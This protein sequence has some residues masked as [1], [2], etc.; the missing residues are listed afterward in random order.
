[1]SAG[2]PLE[3]LCQGLKASDRSA[4]EHL[5]RLFRQDLL[6][7]VQSIVR[8]GTVA[9]DLVQ[10]VFVSLWGLRETLDPSQPLKPYLYRMARNRA[11]RYLRDERIHAEKHV[12]VQQGVVGQRPAVVEPDA[13]FEETV[14][15]QQL[16]VW[17][18]DLP[19]R[20]REALVLSR[21][22][23]L[24]HQDIAALM[25]ISPRTVNNHIMRALTALQ[26]HIRAFEPTLLEP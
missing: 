12:L 7:Y 2:I 11:Y 1:M 17:I 23:H 21:Y 25:D 10:D 22:H 19:E 16:H 18:A 9:H 13:R 4:F 24:S 14:L 5:F 20:Q 15:C 8:E 26:N 6:R 3:E